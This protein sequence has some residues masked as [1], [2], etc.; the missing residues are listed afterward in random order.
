MAR[1]GGT[2][3]PNGLGYRE[4]MNGRATMRELQDRGELVAASA[5]RQSGID[6]V[7]DSQQGLNRIHT[8]V[9]TPGDW[10]SYFR[11]RHYRALLIA[12][13][14]GYGYKTVKSRVKAVHRSKDKGWKNVAGNRLK[15]SVRQAQRAARKKAVR[16]SKAQ[17]T[18]NRIAKGRKGRS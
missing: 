15:H 7:V 6:Y 14:G 1:R 8:R 17:R 11:E 16:P 3:V 4:V 12:T 5:A 10:A 9:S 2:F 18:V 13:N